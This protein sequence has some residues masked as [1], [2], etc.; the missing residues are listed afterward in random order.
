MKKKNE[1]LDL[2]S[3]SI[4]N[5]DLIQPKFIN[6]YNNILDSVLN[7]SNSQNDD[8]YFKCLECLDCPRIIYEKKENKIVIKSY[9]FSHKKIQIYS[10]NE[11]INKFRM[12]KTKEN[13]ET[14]K[15][16]KTNK[17]NLISEKSNFDSFSQS[18]S[19][20]LEKNLLSIDSYN[21]K[22]ERNEIRKKAKYCIIHNCLYT[23]Y[24]EIEELLICDYCFSENFKHKNRIQ[25]YILGERFE[26]IC[27]LISKANK[28]I[29]YIEK[30]LNNAEKHIEKIKNIKDKNIYDEEINKYI[31]EYIEENKNILLISTIILDTYKYFK[32]KNSL[33]FHIIKNILELTFYFNSIPSENEENYKMKLINYL[34]NP[35]N[36]IINHHLTLLISK[37]FKIPDE[38]IQI[39]KNMF[40]V[41]KITRIIK[42]P[43]NRLCIGVNYM[44]H[45]LNYQLEELF[46]FES[47]PI[48]KIRIWD[49]QLL[50][51]GRVAILSS[52]IEYQFCNFFKI[53]DNYAE[54]VG[55]I[56]FDIINN[57]TFNCFLILSNDYIAIHTSHHLY[58]FTIPK[59]IN[60]KTNLVLKEEYIDLSIE[61]YSCLILRE[62]KDN[63]ISFFSIVSGYE[64]VIQWEFNLE[65]KKINKPFEL[66]YET[67]IYYSKHIGSVG[68]FDNNYF[69]I[70][71]YEFKGFY[72]IKYIDG[73]LYC[74]C[75]PYIQN[76]YQGF[77]IMPDNTFV[78]GENYSNQMFCLKR[79]Q[80]ID[81]DYILIDNI[82]LENDINSIKSNPT[83]I[84]C[85]DNSTVIVGDY[86]G[87][88]TLWG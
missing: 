60:E 37:S 66:G 48:Y 36:Y 76:H 10:L 23:K 72:L 78:F 20:F 62:K 22:D 70:G 15:E 52:N 27:D 74:N 35:N 64:M 9:C 25:K 45:I 65:T 80:M 83:T 50:S 69:I 73:K 3:N 75:I 58:I 26:N 14:K 33:T 16:E 43:N 77:C 29:N 12:T 1:Y 21:R 24:C 56:N 79:Y 88:I 57:E 17:S 67:G 81:K 59:N 41:N 28:K 63:I 42:I 47:D 68:K 30:S 2:E 53:Y 71:G 6:T 40:K 54:L 51:D 32:E 46:K 55:K 31:D 7:T 86:S 34:K 19:I 85:L 5:D 49:I 8:I 4:S 11:F 13:E 38:E 18:N 61:V 84:I 87:R 82:S 44:I 39:K